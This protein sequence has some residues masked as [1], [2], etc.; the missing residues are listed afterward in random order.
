MWA[1]LKLACLLITASAGSIVFSF[2]SMEFVLKLACLLITATVGAS[3]VMIG[4][5][6]SEF[7]YSHTSKKKKKWKRGYRLIRRRLYRP[8]YRQGRDW[9]WRRRSHL[10]NTRR[11]IFA[12]DFK[13]KGKEFFI[14]HLK[15]AIREATTGTSKHQA[16]TL[17]IKKC[18]YIYKGVKGITPSFLARKIRDRL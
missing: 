10:I 14:V 16:S 11:R 9:S 7:V 4:V 18:K 1:N 13:Q 12:Y 6:A 8:S 17:L 5:S 2:I 15:H 3:A